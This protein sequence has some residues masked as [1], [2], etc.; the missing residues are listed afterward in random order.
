MP[1]GIESNSSTIKEWETASEWET[2]NNCW[3]RPRDSAMETVGRIGAFTHRWYD[4]CISSEPIPADT[5]ERVR[6]ITAKH[7]PQLDSEVE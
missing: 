1:Y 2:V 3:V 7:F 4:L 5:V 6:K